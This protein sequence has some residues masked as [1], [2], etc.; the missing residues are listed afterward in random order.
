MNRDGQMSKGLWKILTIV[1]LGLAAA[2][3]AGLVATDLNSGGTETGFS[4]GWTGSGNV[5]IVTASDLSYASYGITQTGTP[6]GVYACN[7]THNDRED[8]RNVA[9][10]MSGEIWF[11]ALVTVPAGAGFA[12]LS[13]DDTATTGG[14]DRYS[15]GLSELR[16]VL[17]SGALIVDMDGGAPPTATG[18]ETGSFAS[19]TT[20]LMLGQLIVAAGNDTVHVWIDPNVTA[21]GGP[22]GLP[23]ANF[24]STTV[25]FMDSMA[26]I[27]VPL[28]W[29][30]TASPHVDAIRLSDTATA[31]EDVTGIGGEDTTP[32]SVS[33]LSPTNGATNVRVD[34]DLV[35]TFD[36]AVQKGD[37]NIVIQQTAGG[38]FETIPVTSS[39]VVIDGETVT[40]TPS[41]FL[42]G[43]TAYYVEIDSGAF[44][45]FAPTP[46][47]FAGI[48]GSGA[49]AF[50][51][52]AIDVTPP[53][54]SDLNP[55]NGAIEV[56]TDADLVITFD[57][58]VQAGSGNIVIQQI[59]SG[60][61]E[62]LAVTSAHVTVSGAVVTISPSNRFERSASYY[63]EIDAGTFNDLA[64]TPNDF[65]GISGSTTWRFEISSGL[66]AATDLNGGGT[67]Q[68]F[69][70]GWAGS[71]KRR[72]EDA[73]D[74]S[75][76][77]DFIIQSGTTERVYGGSGNDHPDRMDSRDLGA[78]MSGEIWF[79]V[80]VEVTDPGTGNNRF[81]GLSFHGDTLAEPAADYSHNQADMRVLMTPS[82]LWIDWEGAA[83]NATWSPD[84]T[85]GSFNAG[86]HLMLGQMVVG[87]GNDTLR[88]WVDPDLSDVSGPGGLPAAAYSNTSVDF[89]ESVV[90][91]GV[92][93]G[94]DTYDAAD[95]IWLSD[96]DTAFYDVTGV[97][98]IPAGT[99]IL[100][101]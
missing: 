84:A 42:A 86:T 30:N 49:W 72:I 99:V 66:L 81:A 93:L 37:G 24:T 25:D 19:G 23:T 11:T 2:S 39:D 68:G 55:A 63:V 94:Y 9:A 40:I 89:A 98:G 10:V 20:H 87:A 69:S 3:H 32:P 1:T 90:R 80:L 17:T 75:Y 62:T 53:E 48:S 52:K 56:A 51:T 8:S 97:S 46:N 77:N 96:R 18:T 29:N 83:V 6:G 21:A 85:A 91:I 16:V 100:V 65:G 76:D 12:G 43:T 88:V 26:Q 13:F 36:E 79:S 61:F 54:N 50:T 45:D 27:G 35:V 57:E 31:F 70:G 71:S 44:T 34:A 67:D 92:P 5:F 38:V 73:T 41:S 60:I 74:L 7:T 33:E 47:D 14:K 59:A 64:A 82:E 101:Q 15:H 58:D 28:S 4:G 22:G 95:A 78:T